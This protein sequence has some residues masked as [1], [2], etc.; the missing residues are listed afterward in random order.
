MFVA[1]I[2]YPAHCWQTVH[3]SKYY[4]GF[5]GDDMQKRLRRYNSNH[6]GFTGGIG[7]WM[8]AYTESYPTKT[9]AY[10]RERQVKGWKSR[11]KIEGLMLHCNILNGYSR[12]H[13][14]LVHRSI[15]LVRRLFSIFQAWL[16]LCSFK[17]QKVR[18][19]HW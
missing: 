1:E 15:L 16:I 8:I 18:N 6:R 19:P 7:D 10:T 12:A 17:T 5:T 13:T 9:V 11:K 3:L 14:L 2:Q 4:T